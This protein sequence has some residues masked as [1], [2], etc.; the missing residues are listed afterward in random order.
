M[1]NNPTDPMREAF[2]NEINKLGRRA[3]SFGNQL[4]RSGCGYVVGATQAAWVGFQSGAQWQMEQGNGNSRAVGTSSECGAHEGYCAD[5]VKEHSAETEAASDES[6]HT[7][8]AEAEVHGG[9][10]ITAEVPKQVQILP[11]ATP[12]VEKMR[13][14]LAAA[15]NCIRLVN[16][17]EATAW[18]D[19]SWA[20]LRLIDTALNPT[21]QEG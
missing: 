7:V 10:A 6:A 17:E 8:N 11:V 13:A 16:R 18:I 5:N 20:T 1:S 14:A 2:E 3:F 9:T 19:R 4:V 15:E 21:G 12:A